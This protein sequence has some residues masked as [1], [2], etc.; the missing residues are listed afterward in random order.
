M[1]RDEVIKWLKR[2]KQREQKKGGDYWHTYA[3]TAENMIQALKEG[4]R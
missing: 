2:Y 3:P 1:T 4:K